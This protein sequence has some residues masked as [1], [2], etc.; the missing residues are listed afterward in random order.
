[1]DRGSTALTSEVGGAGGH[2]AQ[3]QPARQGTRPTRAVTLL[4]F[5]AFA[6]YAAAFIWRTSFVVDGVRTFCLFD[7]GM[8]SMRYARN[9]AHGYGLVWNPGGERVEGFTNPLWTA[10]MAL[11]H[12]LPVSASKISL[13]IQ[14]T[15]AVCLFA[16]LFFI[17]RLARD[18]SGGSEFAA[19]A[20][21]ALAG[22]S[23]PV[24]NW[25]LQ[26]LE[27]GPLVLLLSAAVSVALRALATARFSLLPYLLL[28][29]AT[30][31]RL[32]AFV[33]IA[34]VTLFGLLWD[35][36]HRRQHLLAGLG[37][38]LLFGGGQT[39]LR[40]WY[41]GDPLP[42]TYYLK[43]TGYPAA[44]RLLHGAM[45]Y[46]DFVI[47]LPWWLLLV[48]FVPMALRRTHGHALLALLFLTQSAYSIYVGG[49]AWEWWGGANRYLC[50]ALPFFLLLVALGL[51]Q[52]RRWAT[53]ALLAS[54]PLP[55]AAVRVAAVLA[56]A[57]CLVFSNACGP[58][59]LREWLLLTPPLHREDNA[60]NVRT[61]ALLR[62]ATTPQA[63]VALSWAGAIPYF[64]DRPCH[65][66]LGKSDRHIA[67]ETVRIFLNWGMAGG[68]VPGHLKYD[69]DYSVVKLQPDVMLRDTSRGPQQKAFVAAHY[70]PYFLGEQEALLRLDSPNIRWD[71]LRRLDAAERERRWPTAGTAAPSRSP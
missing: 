51:D 60:V 7:D 45:A 39:L 44:F 21:V 57:A 54:P 15:S 8:V 12:L 53:A 56:V 38:L 1:M 26:G 22:F 23:L 6:V 5:S 18:L 24:L 47:A 19:L 66:L 35:R 29:V 55:R 14:I 62:Q 49:D 61:A 31:L 71:V 25:S 64:S 40:L 20:A 36:P 27:V 46:Y 28:G 3:D 70:R 13:P 9:L 17:K 68:F 58:T 69:F 10:Y 16:S 4:L 34:T 63:L 11:W 65:D 52:M 42:N 50:L 2:T 33:V 67:H 37:T 32:D 41:F 59:T 48:A 43:L 30:L